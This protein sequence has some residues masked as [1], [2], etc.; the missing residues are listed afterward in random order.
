MSEDRVL[1][2]QPT[3]F[4]IDRGAIR[5]NGEVRFY[6]LN[7]YVGLRGRPAEAVLIGGAS[8]DVPKLDEVLGC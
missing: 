1:D 2:S 7:V 6:R 8:G 4:P 3:P 5:K